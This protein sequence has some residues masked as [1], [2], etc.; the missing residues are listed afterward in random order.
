MNNTSTN[1]LQTN[2]LYFQIGLTEWNRNYG[3]TSKLWFNII[4]VLDDEHLI[5]SGS[6]IPFIQIDNNGKLLYN[7]YYEEQTEAENNI[8]KFFG[9]DITDL[10]NINPQKVFEIIKKH[11]DK[12]YKY[13]EF[14]N[15]INNTEGILKSNTF[16]KLHVC[17]YNV[18]DN[19]YLHFDSDDD[20]MSK[21][22]YMNFKYVNDSWMLKIINKN[23]DFFAQGSP[24]TQECGLPYGTNTFPYIFVSYDETIVNDEFNKICIIFEKELELIINRKKNRNKKKNQSKKSKKNRSKINNL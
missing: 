24:C 14:S 11:D 17:E 23:T 20:V 13:F 9:I 2:G 1:I 18:Q 10:R 3:A 21:W 6:F 5:S 8:Y 22:I 15:K 19:A 7:D 16:N 4:K 12:F